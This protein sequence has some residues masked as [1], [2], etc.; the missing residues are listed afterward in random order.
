MLAKLFVS[1]ASKPKV[2]CRCKGRRQR[3]TGMLPPNASSSRPA[4]PSWLMALS[5]SAPGRSHLVRATTIGHPESFACWMASLVWGITPSSAATTS[6]TRS[7]SAAPL[8]SK[9]IAWGLRAI[10]GRTAD[11]DRTIGELGKYSYFFIEWMQPW[12]LSYDKVISSRH[13]RLP[14]HLFWVMQSS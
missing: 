9:K 5:G 10:W 2:L 3:F 11:H 8:C 7:V 14:S 13:T 1:L 6:T 4:S 12:K